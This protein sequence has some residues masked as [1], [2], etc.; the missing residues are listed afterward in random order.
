MKIET[1]NGQTVKVKEIKY[2]NGNYFGL[3]KYREMG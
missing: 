2:E 3:S 1:N